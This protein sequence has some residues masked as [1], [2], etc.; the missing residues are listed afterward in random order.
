M[1]LNTFLSRLKAAN[2]GTPDVDVLAYG[3]GVLVSG[4]ATI[5]T[6]LS[7]VN[8]FTANLTGTGAK[9]TGAA[10]IA[11]LQIHTIVTGSVIVQGFFNSFVTGTP[12]ISVSGTNTFA[13]MA[14][15]TP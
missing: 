6:G 5:A 12:T 10:E 3:S 8:V 13:W 9:T 11:T 14:I 15:G 7:T 1:P 4:V 2:I